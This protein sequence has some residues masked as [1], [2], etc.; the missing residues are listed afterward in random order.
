MAGLQEAFNRRLEGFN[1]GLKGLS[2]PAG[3]PLQ[4]CRRASAGQRN[5]H[6]DPQGA[7][8][9]SAGVVVQA[10][11]EGP[12]GLREGFNRRLECFNP[13]L[14]PSCRPAEAPLRPGRSAPAGQRDGSGGPAGWLLR[15]GILSK[16]EDG[17]LFGTELPLPAVCAGAHSESRCHKTNRKK[18]Q[19][20]HVAT[21]DS[22]PPSYY[23]SGIVYAD[24]VVPIPKQNKPMAKIRRDWSRKNRAERLTFA[25]TVST[26]IAAS[27]VL[28]GLSPTAA[29]FEILR[30]KAAASEQAVKDN[31]VVLAG[32]RATAA[33]DMDALLAG[34]ENVALSA[35]GITHGEAAGLATTG[36]NLVTAGAPGPSIDMT[37]VINFSLT[38]G[39]H[40]QQ[41]S[42]HCDPV[43]M[44]RGYNVQICYDMTATPVWE[45][46]EDAPNTQFTIKNL[47]SG[48]RAW[49]RMRAF[50]TNGPGPWSDP[51]TKII[52]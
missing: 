39:D 24:M 9:R 5:G 25:Q 46:L 29:A 20:S 49:V 44:A 15:A 7:F 47:T 16:R 6:A 34:M 50:G 26:A 45:D 17:L 40:D 23:D 14:K 22:D 42:G 12:A 48:R 32:L 13:R 27:T 2:R 36:F 28:T 31:A 33:A 35:E 38:A 3:V 18:K 41:L 11:K 30:A 19:R 21:Y 4:P 8:S 37:Q 51:A 1:P 10:R 43:D 52:P